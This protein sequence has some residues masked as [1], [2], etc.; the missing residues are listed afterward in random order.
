MRSAE[1]HTDMIEACC[2]AFMPCIGSLVDF[3]AARA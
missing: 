1:F 3:D 2:Y